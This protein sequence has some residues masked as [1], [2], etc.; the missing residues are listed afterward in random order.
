[1]T[2]TNECIN[3]VTHANRAVEQTKFAYKN[4]EVRESAKP[5]FHSR[6]KWCKNVVNVK[7]LY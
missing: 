1:M 6:D 2:F 5:P 4:S 7:I 3:D